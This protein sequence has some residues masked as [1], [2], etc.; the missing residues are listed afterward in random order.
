MVEARSHT[1]GIAATNAHVL[2]GAEGALLVDAPEGTCAWLESGGWRPVALLLTHAHFDHVTEAAEVSRRWHCPIHAFSTPTPELT[3]EAFLPFMGVTAPLETYSVDHPF[4][5]GDEL[6]LAGRRILVRHLPG[7]SPDSV[8]FHLPDEGLVFS[9]DTLMR[10]S[11]G[12][13]DFPGGS[14]PTLLEGIRR[15]LLTLPGEVSVLPGHGGATSIATERESN[16]FLAT[17]PA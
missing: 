13:T 7:H 17:S 4:A 14:A 6:M 16:P 5:D 1:G 10:G 2:N 3:L 9:G 15:H 12:R 8:I 11:I